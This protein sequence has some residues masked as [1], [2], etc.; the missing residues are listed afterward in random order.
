[1]AN[2]NISSIMKKVRNFA[3]SEEGKKRSSECIRKYRE[4][5]RRTTHSG[6]EI[7]TK[8]RMME[9]AQELIELLKSAANSYDLPNS[10]KAHFDS[11]TVIFEDAK[12]DVDGEFICYIYFADDLSRPSL[13]N[14]YRQWDGINNIVAL[15]NN[16]YVAS[17]PKFGWWNDHKPQ[18]GSVYRSGINSSDA[19]IRG[20]QAR[21]SL[22]FMQA[23]IEDFYSK[24]AKKYAMTLTLNDIYD[25]DY[26]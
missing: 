19:Y 3:D 2:I 23:T 22:R 20:T 11:L 1:M 7:L 4:N 26:I 8:S 13:E 5:N 25:G 6:V 24:Y 14:D 17:K 21:P 12:N 16:G 10:V 9:L 18:S 15:F